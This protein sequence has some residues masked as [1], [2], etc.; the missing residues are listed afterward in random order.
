MKSK[1]LQEGGDGHLRLASLPPLLTE[2]YC[3]YPQTL[4]SLFS[5]HPLSLRFLTSHLSEATQR[6]PVFHYHPCPFNLLPFPV[7]PFLFTVPRLPFSSLAFPSQHFFFFPFPAPPLSFHSLL[8]YLLPSTPGP[9]RH[10]S[11]IQTLPQHQN[12]NW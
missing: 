7:N 3:V 9:F 2:A 6:P 1:L 10:P 11:S 4:P 8:R 12:L 5:F